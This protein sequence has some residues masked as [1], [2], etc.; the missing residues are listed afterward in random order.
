MDPAIP[1]I[2]AISTLSAFVF[3]VVGRAVTRRAVSPELK[4][5]RD[6][7]GLWWYGLGL[8]SLL[9]VLQIAVFVLRG[10][11][12]PMLNTIGI[13]SILALCAA[14]WGLLSYLV[15]LFTNS[16]RYRWPLAIAYG[17]FFVFIVY[18]IEVLNVQE[19][20]LKGYQLTS[21]EG[22]SLQGSALALGFI[23]ALLLPQML[24]ALAYLSLYPKVQDPVQRRRVLLVGLSILIWFGSAFLGLIEA[25]ADSPWWQL[26]SRLIGLAAA[27]V[28]YYAYTKLGSTGRGARPEVGHAG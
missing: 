10:N 26:A 25:L 21:D 4:S 20:H 8:T 7:F 24:A 16:Q 3:L 5:V 1:V 11:D 27:G 12:I 23:V 6:A 22:E 28:I 19:Y 14:L 18:L 13:V 9:G 17:L 2:L 15:F